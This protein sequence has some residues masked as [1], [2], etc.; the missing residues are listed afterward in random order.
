MIEIIPAIL[1]NDPGELEDR[2]KQVERLAHRVQVDIIDGVFANNRTVALE[3]LEGIGTEALLDVHL[4]VY[5]PDSWVERAVRILADRIIGQV[6]MMSDQVRFIGHAQEIGSKVGLALDL[7]TPVSAIDPAIINNLDV[8]L[9]MSVKAGFGGQEFNKSALEK[10]KAL[11]EIRSRDSIPFRICVDGGIN[12]QN[13]G[14]IR[15]AGAD[16][17]AIGRSLF[18]GDL[19][20]NIER[21]K[22]TE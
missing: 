19:A 9:L 11:D 22:K 13:I 3:S 15:R 10:I 4:M 14:R 7:P 18:A 17:A 8:V 6:E 16:E 1:T 21:L 5:E 20:K 12:A 2:I